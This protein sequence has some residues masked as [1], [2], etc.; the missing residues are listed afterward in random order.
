MTNCETCHKEI[1]GRRRDARFCLECYNERKLNRMREWNRINYKP[2]PP[3][4][5]QTCQQP[6]GRG[7]RARFCEPCLREHI[8]KISRAR[9]HAQP[10][11]REEKL[12]PCKRCLTPTLSR[13][14]RVLCIKCRDAKNKAHSRMYYRNNPHN[15]GAHFGRI[16]ASIKIKRGA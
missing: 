13:S 6:T 16:L 2:A 7:K 5:C 10:T 1:T 4:L 9:R 14:H 12:I 8:R 11:T 3:K 15:R